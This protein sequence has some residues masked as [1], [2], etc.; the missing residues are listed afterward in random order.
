MKYSILTTLALI[1]FIAPLS[2]QEFEAP[3]DGAKIYTETSSIEVNQQGETLFDLWIVR[4]NRAKRTHFQ[5]PKISGVEGLEFYFKAD[6]K[7]KDHYTVN[8]KATNAQLGSY[9]G[10]IT[11]RSNG[12]QLVTGKII[13]INVLPAASIASTD[14]E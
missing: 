10:T 11:S 4:S 5:M 8:V 7:N 6:P 12:I 2:A 13:N 3:K 1:I 9:S 14:G